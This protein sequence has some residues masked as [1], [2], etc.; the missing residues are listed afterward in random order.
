MDTTQFAVAFNQLINKHWAIRC[1]AVIVPPTIITTMLKTIPDVQR[2]GPKTT[3]TEFMGIK[4]IVDS[5]VGDHMVFIDHKGSIRQ[6][7]RIDYDKE[8]IE[9]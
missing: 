4:V 3:V 8:T 6:I 5:N 1:T 9:V 2:P 7:V